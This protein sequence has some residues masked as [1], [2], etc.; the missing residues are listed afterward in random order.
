MDF[1][2]DVIVRFEMKGCNPSYTTGVGPELSLNM[3]EENSPNEEETKRC[4]S[5][6][7][8]ILDR[9]PDTSSLPLTKWGGLLCKP[10]K[11]YMGAAKH[12]LRFLAG[13]VTFSM[14]YRR[15]NSTPLYIIMLVNDPISL[16]H[17]T[18][19]YSFES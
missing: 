9:L 2:G 16:K 5:T 1:K 15:A 4:Q 10:P 12:P 18:G 7:S 13:S 6:L 11:A 8:C 19:T 14:A 3:A 17:I